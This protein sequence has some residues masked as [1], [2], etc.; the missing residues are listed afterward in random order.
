V[1]EKIKK[2]DIAVALLISAIVGIE[3]G[4]ASQQI[5]SKGKGSSHLSFARQTAM[6]LM[7][8][9]FQINIARV[10]RAF[11]RDPSTVSHACHMIEDYREDPFFDDKLSRLEYFLKTAPVPA[12]ISKA[13]QI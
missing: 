10:A 12:A 4:V 5:F 8:V 3:L 9:V 1:R 11:N 13:A 2:Y 6:Y 7:H